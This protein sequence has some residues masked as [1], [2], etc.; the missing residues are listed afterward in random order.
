MKLKEMMQKGFK[1]RAWSMKKVRGECFIAV[2]LSKKTP[3]REWF[4]VAHSPQVE[5]ILSD[6]EFTEPVLL[7]E[8]VK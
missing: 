3:A 1:L 6:V 7:K 4:Y 8:A 5:T 2:K